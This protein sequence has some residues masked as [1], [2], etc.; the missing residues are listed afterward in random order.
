MTKVF[1]AFS[2]PL[3]ILLCLTTDRVAQTSTNN[4]APVI[5][6]RRFRLIGV[7]QSNRIVA[8]IKKED[9]EVRV[10][11]VVYSNFS[12][13]VEPSPLL[14]IL[15]L[16]SSG[17]MRFQF[18]DIIN[19]SKTIIDQN[20]NDDATLL[21]RFV[22]IKKIKITEK[23]TSDKG[24][25]L[26]NLNNFVV[27]GGRTALVEAIYKSVQILAGQK[28][29]P[30]HQRTLIIFSDGEDRRSIQSEDQL[31][32]LLKK[33]QIPV[34]FIGLLEDIE[35]VEKSKKF[36]NRVVEASGGAAMF[37][38]K[39]KH[40]KSVSDKILSGIRN[41]IFVSVPLPTGTHDIQINPSKGGK[42]KA[43]KYYVHENK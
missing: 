39:S 40:L 16:D 22:D 32:E 38:K 23:F 6:T 31:Y 3:V 41:R 15:S 21:M 29:R 20:S 13:S 34:F 5:E 19:A 18:G 37:F 24:F 8:D 35:K 27:G 1:F 4:P 9:I 12:I 30:D 11:G 14:Y 28:G 26:K 10:N 33:E 25:L 36:I 2:I 17:S 7:D 42:K 43:L